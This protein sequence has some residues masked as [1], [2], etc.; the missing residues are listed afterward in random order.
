[1]YIF[2]TTLSD[3][4]RPL[5]TSFEDSI[6]MPQHHNNRNR[7][8]TQNS[9]IN[10][11]AS[12]GT[13]APETWD[14]AI[15]LYGWDVPR[16]V[17]RGRNRPMS[18]LHE[19]VER[20]PPRRDID[21]IVP[22]EEETHERDMRRRARQEEGL[23]TRF[24]S[25]GHQ[26]EPAL[27][28]VQIRRPGPVH[29]V[30]VAARRGFRSHAFNILQDTHSPILKSVRK[31]QDDKQDPFTGAGKRRGSAKDKYARVDEVTDDEENAKL[32]ICK[33]V[34]I[35]SDVAKISPPPTPDS[36]PDMEA[37]LSDSDW[38]KPLYATA[39]PRPCALSEEE[40]FKECDAIAERMGEMWV[41]Q[42]LKHSPP[43]SPGHEAAKPDENA[44]AVHSETTKLSGS[45]SSNS[46][47]EDLSVYCSSED[48]F[49]MVE[50]P[51]NSESE[52]NGARRKWYK[53]FLR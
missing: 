41:S 34:Q 30:P 51:T 43:E 18:T 19:I 38:A 7:R 33:A 39:N 36:I 22:G 15:H 17:R 5:N 9:R 13:P 50:V 53:G 8:Q 37:E 25:H 11:E 26:I 14:D 31:M 27:S 32:E 24:D 28:A 2:K 42:K 40:V 16:S 46:S 23:F 45:I 4:E 47:E 29:Q 35:K 49:E 21:W 48:D 44:E 10:L 52:H 20:E 6:H 3:L 12:S 1:M